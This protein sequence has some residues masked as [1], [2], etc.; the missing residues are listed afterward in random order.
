MDNLGIQMKKVFL[1]YNHGIYPLLGYFRNQSFVIVLSPLLIINLLKEFYGFAN[2]EGG[3]KVGL[4]K[5]ISAVLLKS[6]RKRIELFNF[7]T[8][9]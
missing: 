5:A 4:R 7:S 9:C 8:V 1:S 6:K 3:Q 2:L